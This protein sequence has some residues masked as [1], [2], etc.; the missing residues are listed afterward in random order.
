M[1]LV[2][3]AILFTPLLNYAQAKSKIDSVVIN[4]LKSQPNTPTPVLKITG[5]GKKGTISRN[6]F[7]NKNQ[8]ITKDSV[9]ITTYLFGSGAS[10]STVTHLL[11]DIMI[12]K[13]EKYRIIESKTVEEGI[14]ELMQLI[15][16]F[17]LSD[18][19]KAILIN[20]LTVAYY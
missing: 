3:F 9:T 2:L 16:P 8:P 11:L 18:S 13:K 5:N 14:K 1:K 10:H 20:Q 15:Q 17:N 19:Q 7:W 6:Y 12:P 4:F